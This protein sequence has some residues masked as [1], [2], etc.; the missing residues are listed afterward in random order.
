[1]KTVFDSTLLRG[2]RLK[3]RLIR[4]ATWEGLAHPDGTL[5]DE[6]IRIYEELAKG[7]VAAIVTGLTNVSS[8]GTTLAGAMSLAHDELVPDYRRL[9]DVVKAQDCRIITQLALVDFMRFDDTHQR[10]YAIEIDDLDISEIEFVV[11]E[12]AKAASRAEKAGFDGVQI[13]AA[14]NF[15]LS[16]CISPLH[17]HRQ[18][19]YGGTSEKRA[20]ILADIYKAIRQNAP[21]LHISTKINFHDFTLGGT[22]PS[23]AVAICRE[24]EMAGIDSIEVSANGTSRTSTLPGKNEAYFLPFAAQLKQVVDTPVILVGGLRSLETMN[25]VLNRTPVEYFALSRPLIRQPAFPKLWQDGDTNPATCISCNGCY[26]SPGHRCVFVG[27]E[28]RDR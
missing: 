24:L 9:T 11:E 18:D 6:L 2:M 20:R 17:N 28:K 21:D 16:R 5:T 8:R 15:Y 12:F 25:G 7:G 1:M 13:H 27:K 14:H 4:S 10:E 23:D 22:T 19:S 26:S 3:N